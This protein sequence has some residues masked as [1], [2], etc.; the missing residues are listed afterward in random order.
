M[1]KSAAFFLVFF[2]II[3]NPFVFAQ[4]PIAGPGA[5]SLPPGLEKI[6]VVAAIHGTVELKMPGQAGR[7]A[8]SGEPVFIGQ[9]V[10]TNEK[11]NLQ[12]LLLDETVF[13]IGPNSSI[14]IDKFIYDPKSHDGEIRASIT[15]GI[16]RYVS[17]KIAAKRSSSVS[18]KLPTATIGF[19][20]TIVA[21]Q[22]APA[23][24]FAMLL[25]PGTNNDIGSGAGSFSIKGE[26]VHAGEERSVTQTGFGVE[27]NQS[28][29]LSN[30]FKVPDSRVN[31]VTLSLAPNQGQGGG[32]DSGLGGGESAGSL[33]GEK[34]VIAGNNASTVNTLATVTQSFV[35]NTTKAAQDQASGGGGVA[36][37]GTTT[38]EQLRAAT[39]SGH[40]SN[41]GTYSSSGYSTQAAGNI[42]FGPSGSLG[43]GN[44]Y[45]SISNGTYTDSTDISGTGAGFTGSGPASFHWNDTVSSGG[46]FDITATLSN[47]D[48]VTAQNAVVTITYTNP[49]GPSG[50]TLPPSGTGTVSGTLSSGALS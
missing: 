33:S 46:V 12:I 27:V 34:M 21:G 45:V 49:G 3:S 37:N 19:R 50:T 29:A 17:G 42:V 38:Y 9:D 28:G 47:S 36:P 20:G 24:S 15:K 8:Q 32:K 44:S 14:T 18:V 1:K 6:G 4:M 23:A 16:F 13:T 25:G 11:G 30:V 31:N 48:G 26:G 2:L 40:Y 7:I 5:L 10:R 41:D 22:V 35:D 39:G 43:G